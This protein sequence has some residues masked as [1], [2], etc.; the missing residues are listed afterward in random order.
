MR[1]RRPYLYPKQFDALYSQSR[2]VLVEAST[3]SG[4]T[5]GSMVRFVEEGLMN[6]SPYPNLWWIAPTYAQSDIAFERTKRYL[7]K[8]AI[9]SIHNTKK[10]IE[11]KNGSLL[12]FKSAQDSDLLYGEDVYFAV[13][14]EA[15]R[16]SEDSW[17]AIR[18]TLTA[19]RGRVVCIGNVR[20]RLNWFYRLCRKAEKGLLSD[21]RYAMIDASDA[22]D[23]GVFPRSEYES[24]KASMNEDDFNELYHC[25]PRDLAGNP[26]GY[27]AIQRCTMSELSG[28]APIAFGV[29]LGKAN[30]YTVIIGLDS[31]GNMSHFDRFREDWPKTEERVLA[32]L[33]GRRAVVDKTGVGAPLCDNMR[34]KNPR[35]KGLVFSMSSK[36]KLMGALA[37]AIH[38]EGI[39]YVDAVARELET[40][41]YR[42]S[43]AGVHY[44]AASGSHDD[45][46]DALALAW[47]CLGKRG[48]KIVQGGIWT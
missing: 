35:I 30:D 4:K 17:V 7:S 43:V 19:T 37:K 2:Y 39:G 32:A 13:I 34:L 31:D 24:A 36:Q 29:D 12:I 3:K 25:K 46:V 5:V 33:K 28:K 11:L 38:Q 26:F 27:D 22:V 23:A 8:N 20:G 6:R 42:H 15:S 21:A 1:F 40:F 9:K 48:S 14:D 45:C 16:V 47:R 18:S 44:E 10:Q 41:E